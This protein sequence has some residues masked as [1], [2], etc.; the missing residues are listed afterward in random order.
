MNAAVGKAAIAR[1]TAWS[2][3]GS[4]A[5]MAV[6]LLLTP[7]MADRLGLQRFGVWVVLNALGVW[8]THVDLGLSTALSREVPRRLAAGDLAGLARLQGT[9][10]FYDVACL[11]VFLLAALPLARL[12]APAWVAGEEGAFLLL[13]AQFLL[14]PLYR[15]LGAMLAG[16]QRLDRVAR[17]GLA[18]LPLSTSVTVGVLLAGGGLLPLAANGLAWLLVQILALAWLVRREGFPMPGRPS[19]TEFE[20]LLGFGLKAHVGRLVQ[21]LFRSDR[22]LLALGGLA[23]A[24]IAVYQFGAGLAERLGGLVGELSAALPAAVSDLEAR[25]EAEKVRKAVLRAT[26]LHAVAALFL[27]GFAACFAA[28]LLQFWLGAADPRSVAVLR[29][30]SLAAFFTGVGSPLHA[31][32]AALGWPG[33]SALALALGWTVAAM[34]YM[35][36][37]RGYDLWGLA[38]SLTSGW[39]AAQAVMAGLLRRRVGFT[40]GEI[41]GNALLKPAVVLAPPAAAYAAWRWGWPQGAGPGRTGALM[42]LAPAFG[43][44]AWAAWRPARWAGAIERDDVELLRSLGRREPA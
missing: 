5:A 19:R 13:A 10:L 7:L 32:A 41:L 9:W 30:L 6:P 15:H 31:A 25:G 24:S 36:W 2:V 43:L 8:L 23:P 14:A 22:L 20:A 11:A 18:V 28:E 35:I 42:I 33:R 4:L 39:G 44:A 17:L 3:A 12:L 37:G 29:I 40:W 21:Q 1:N 38:A 16:A 34:L 27:L 26:R